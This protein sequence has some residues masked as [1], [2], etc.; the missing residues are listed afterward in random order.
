MADW[1][2]GDAEN[3]LNLVRDIASGL[4]LMVIDFPRLYKLVL[5]FVG[6]AVAHFSIRL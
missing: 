5:R 3:M 2:V 6:L 1:D 4:F